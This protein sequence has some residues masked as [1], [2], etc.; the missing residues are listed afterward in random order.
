[1]F[2]LVNVEVMI[3]SVKQGENGANA[4]NK[5]KMR[6]TAIFIGIAKVRKMV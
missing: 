2:K 4:R 5:K 6:L 3:S 1:M